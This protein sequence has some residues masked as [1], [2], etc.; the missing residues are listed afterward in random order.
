MI[1]RCRLPLSIS[2]VLL[3]LN[4]SVAQ[5]L[6][7]AKF[8]GRSDPFYPIDSWW[9]TPGEQRLASGAPG[10]AYWQQRADYV[11]DVTLDDE[12][13]RISGQETIR[14]QNLSPHTL[15][16]VWFQL[17]QN[18]YRPDSEGLLGSPA[19]SLEGR[20]PF[21][22]LRSI[23][24]RE[25][26]QGGFDISE[27]ADS[28]G[29]PLPHHILGTEMRVD[30]PAPLEPGE[31]IELRIAFA[32]RI[33]DAKLVFGRG[34]YEFFEKDDNY[35]YEIAQWYP[36]VV[37][38][39]DYSG[40][41]HEPY[42]GHGEFTLDFGNYTVHITAP[43][44]M[45]V[46]STGELNNP[47]AVLS[48][49]QRTRLADA[50][51]SNKPIFIVTPDEAKA[52]QAHPKTA[53]RSLTKTW[54]FTATNVRDFAFAASR[55]F[56]WDAVG[57]N[58][59]GRPVMA[60]SYYPIEAE[61]LWSQY[62]T[63]AIT[64]TLDVYSRFTFDYPYPV[65]ISVNG[66]V[67]GMEYP[68][69][70]FN[71]P[72]PETDGTYS[73]ATKYGLISVIIHE[74]GHNWFP[75]IV[76]SDE[77]RWTWMDE[78]LNTFLQY[79]AEQEWETDYPSNRGEPEN[80]TAFMR[81]NDQR[82]IMTQ[83]ESLLQFGN[84]AYAKPA[85]A[86]NILRETILGRELFD[87]AFKEY[88]RRWRFKR[89]IPEDFFRTME[90]A[91]GVDLDWFW[92]GWFYTTDHVDVAI[93]NVK[94][95]QIDT[96]DPD[97]NAE[98][99]RREKSEKPDS[100]SKQRNEPLTKRV[101]LEPGLK[102]FYNDYDKLQVTEEDRNSFRKFIDGLNAEERK[103]IKRKTNFYVVN[104][105]NVG[106]LVTPI[107]LTIRYDDATSDRLQIPA[108]IWRQDPRSVDKLIIT[109]KTISQLELD[110][111]RQ[112]ADTDTSNDHWPPKLVPSRF[113]LFKDEVSK[114]PMQ[115]A[116]EPKT[117]GKTKQQPD[118]AETDKPPGKAA[119]EAE[120]EDPQPTNGRSRAKEA[121]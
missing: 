85:T 14:Y 75:M 17:D 91:S 3:L 98:Q 87:F 60:M 55:K 5:E 89:P 10:P 34:G 45:I 31:T 30:L 106:G 109:D 66:P 4:Y 83:S 24:A 117:D 58:V 104:F 82:P 100:V 50:A 94:L 54:E 102:D 56:I 105:K 92:R 76:N 62:S 37:A 99:K 113:K 72:R 69:I 120:V 28:E 49:A 8:G 116:A 26:F 78:G 43:S 16:Y 23:L 95:Y 90:D 63:H 22:L 96:S 47:L 33:L 19:P 103:L 48:L 65:A 21:K 40:W 88:A 29:R 53:D 71:G 118:P 27:V 35:L 25:S 61:P 42:V 97:E 86:L 107:I 57:H 38:Y 114:N 13:Q 32:Y 52:N 79:L 68:M 20:V 15:R 108:A 74:V 11:I 111:N 77:R 64:H 36:R 6:P 51:V 115:K 80:I 1:H 18:I 59:G 46:A 67:G 84:V 7:N 70:C 110:P 93:D 101:D 119:S 81:S 121:E 73:K 9:A 41:Q 12:R 44:D 39:T 112:S 2:L